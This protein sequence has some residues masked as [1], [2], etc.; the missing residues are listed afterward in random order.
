MKPGRFG[1]GIRERGSVGGVTKR[2]SMKPGRF[3]P[4]ILAVTP[5]MRPPIK[6]FNEARAFRPGNTRAGD[7]VEGLV[8]E[9]SMK[10]GRFGPGILRHERSRF[11]GA[12][13]FNEAR[14]FRPGNTEAALYP[15]ARHGCFN[16][17]RAFR[18][19]NTH[20]SER[21]S[22]TAATASMK[23]GRFGPGIH[24]PRNCRFCRAQEL[25]LREVLCLRGWKTPSKPR[26][27]F[28]MINNARKDKYILR[29][30]ALPGVFAASQPSTPVGS[31]EL[32]P[33]NR[34]R[35]LDGVG[36]RRSRVGTRK[37]A[38]PHRESGYVRSRRN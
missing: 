6:G 17:A 16:E 27:I 32:P 33:P 31:L 24:P 22:T 25:G 13:R 21:P 5:P 12:G 34:Q 28:T 30:R 10:P 1:P 4:G 2:A 9:A 18:P 37:S 7:L 35:R 29:T 15:E 38:R 23:P 8:A 14:A 11:L 19:G 3:G 36:R 26:N 20:G